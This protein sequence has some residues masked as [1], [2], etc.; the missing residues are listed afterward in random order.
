MVGK[1]EISLLQ[2]YVDLGYFL[3]PV[4]P[5]GKRPATKNGF[6]DATRD[7]KTIAQW[8][9]TNPDFNWAISCEH[10]G[11]FV[12]D[13]DGPDGLK[14]LAA[15]E[16]GYTSLSCVMVNI[17]PRNGYH[18]FFRQPDE[19]LPSTVRRL[20]RRID[21]RGVGGYIVVP[22]SRIDGTEVGEYLAL[23]ELIAPEDLPTPPF[24]LVNL[25]LTPQTVCVP[26]SLILSERT[27][28]DRERSAQ[29]IAR[30]LSQVSEGHRNTSTF[31]AACEMARLGIEQHRA[32][33]YLRMAARV[34]GLPERE[35]VTC[36]NSA[37]K[38]VR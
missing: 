32:E 25:L 30:W 34:N 35:V 13:V 37:Y 12:L 29:R 14:E 3:F 19:R 10:S 15:L 23:D 11:L 20:G 28:E 18:I 8:I 9:K 38:R 1:G 21:T 7:V 4:E 26:D 27:P 36:V 22:P 17:T 24:W 16:A 33:Q 2:R 6:K 5:R 31:W